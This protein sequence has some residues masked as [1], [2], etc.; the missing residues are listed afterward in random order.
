MVDSLDN[1]KLGQYIT[2]FPAPVL[3]NRDDVILMPHIGASTDEAEENCAVMA[4]NQLKDFLENGNIR[5]SVNFPPLSLERTAGYRVAITNRNVPKL[6]GNT[7]SIFANYDIN[8]LDMLNKSREDIAYN[9]IDLE[10]EPSE[11]V[12]NELA[13]VDG[14]INVRRIDPVSV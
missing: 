8:V 12:I 13:A 4:A 10:T 7:L 9:L 5:N 11:D 1:G 14:V 2:D 6:L 3:L